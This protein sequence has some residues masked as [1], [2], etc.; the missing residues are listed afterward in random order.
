MPRKPP[1]PP[2]D[3]AQ[4]KRFVDLAKEAGANADAETFERAFKKVIA[5]KRVIRKGAPKARP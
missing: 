1:L 3:P 5:P 4:S 2:D